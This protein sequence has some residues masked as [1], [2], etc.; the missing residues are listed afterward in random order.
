MYAKKI[1]IFNTFQTY[2]SFS[3]FSDSE[4]NKLIE[5][6]LVMAKFDHLNVMKLIG[7]SPHATD[8]LYIVMPFMIYGSLLSYLRKQRADLTILT[9]ENMDLVRSYSWHPSY[10][11]FT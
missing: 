6:S 10:L 4:Q 5:E 11:V 1:D 7:V 9:T 8:S 3:V 2:S